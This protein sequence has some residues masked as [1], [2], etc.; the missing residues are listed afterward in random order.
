MILR[1]TISSHP[2]LNR[3]RDVYSFSVIALKGFDNLCVY[4]RS[5]MVLRNE[6]LAL[7]DKKALSM[8]VQ[9]SSTGD[10]GS[11]PFIP[12]ES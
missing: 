3:V 5:S 1:C 10:F 2:A 11:Q 12:I 4:P 6:R 9:A 8:R 7:E